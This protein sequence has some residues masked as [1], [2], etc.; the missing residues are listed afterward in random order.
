MIVVISGTDRANSKSSQIANLA[1]Y[2]LSKNS[3][4][5]TLIDLAKLPNELYHP[6]NYK[7]TPDFFKE[8]QEAIF[9]CNGILTV[10]PEYNGSFPGVLKYFID[11]LRFPESFR[12]IPAG[13][14]GLASGSFGGIR[15]IEQLEMI[16][17]YR[18]A[19]IFALRSLF[20][21][22][23]SKINKEGTQITDEFTKNLFEAM[24]LGYIDFVDKIKPFIKPL[25]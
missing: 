13:F 16:F 10:V 9:D 18:E 20:I 24:L 3:V 12:N 7:K 19:H 11:V 6:K 8:T 1:V 17:Q 23:D 22:V 21:H 5:T 4:K 15:A 25:S 14:I 2:F